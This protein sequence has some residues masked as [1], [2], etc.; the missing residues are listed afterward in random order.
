M[1]LANRDAIPCGALRQRV[2]ERP[3][4]SRR[5]ED[6]VASLERPIGQHGCHTFC[7]VA[8][9]R[10]VF[11]RRAYETSRLPSN[12]LPPTRVWK[13]SSQ[14]VQSGSFIESDFAIG[15]REVSTHNRRQVREF[16]SE[17]EFR[18]YRCPESFIVWR[19]GTR[20]LL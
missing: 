6:F 5:G 10:Y 19:A 16:W 17:F 2:V 14:L 9:Q 4:L 13:R 15:P 12:F 7:G 1:E 3:V 20:D 8:K 18:S 11:G